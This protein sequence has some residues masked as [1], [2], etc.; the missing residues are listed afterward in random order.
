MGDRVDSKKFQVFVGNVSAQTTD[1][2]LRSVF[3]VR[4]LSIPSAR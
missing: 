2:K 3:E 4:F 1:E